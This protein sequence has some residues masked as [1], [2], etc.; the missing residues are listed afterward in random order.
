MHRKTWI[1]HAVWGA[2][3]LLLAAAGMVLLAA[4]KEAEGML[5]ALPGILTGVGCG[6]FGSNVGTLLTRMA[7]RKNPQLAMQQAIQEKD[8]RNISINNQAKAR[9]YDLMIWVFSAMML[10]LALSGVSW[11]AVCL[12]AAC[13]LFV[14]AAHVYY[15]H[16]LHKIM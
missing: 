9:A 1:K 5:R 15:L 3:G 10:G 14:V 4:G 11:P 6:L 13:Y 8:E 2:L 12:V 7:A 16:A